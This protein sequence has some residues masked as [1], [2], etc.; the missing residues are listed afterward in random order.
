MICQEPQFFCQAGSTRAKHVPST[1]SL[2]E[3]IRSMG[4]TQGQDPVSGETYW[5][6]PWI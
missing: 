3:R 6:V 4:S 2:V 5:P 1:V